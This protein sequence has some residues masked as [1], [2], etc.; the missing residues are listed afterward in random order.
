MKQS[1]L[2]YYN[3]RSYTKF[4]NMDLNEKKWKVFFDYFDNKHN[5]LDF[6]CGAAWSIYFGKKLGYK[7][8]GLDT[9]NSGMAKEFIE[10]RNFTGVAND[11]ILYDGVGTLPFDDKSFSL[12]VCRASFNKFNTR[13]GERDENIPL[14]IERLREF[15]RITMGEKIVV[16]TGDYF[17]TQFKKFDFKVYYWSKNG[18]SRLWK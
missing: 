13:P 12:I 18:I 1:D 14:A 10:F 16:I 9:I 4:F 17:K 15:D 7:I 11:V 8:A 6:G 5:I 3:S 2:P